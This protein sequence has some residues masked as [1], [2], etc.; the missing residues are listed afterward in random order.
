VLAH[1][2]TPEQ[3]GKVFSR[4]RPKLAVYSHIVGGLTDE[5]LVQMTRTT[6]Q[7]PLVV[8]SDLMAFDVGDSIAVYNIAGV[9]ALGAVVPSR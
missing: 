5:Q 3:A 2:T 7:G 8:G 1:H 4:V 9:S 6:Y